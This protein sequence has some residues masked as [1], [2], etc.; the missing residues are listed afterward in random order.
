MSKSHITR[1]GVQNNFKSCHLPKNESTSNNVS[2]SPFFFW[3]T[4]LSGA[5]T[6]VLGDIFGV[7]VSLL[8]LSP[9]LAGE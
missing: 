8:N 1:P 3:F 2:F 4:I 7:S 9:I 6:D 5:I